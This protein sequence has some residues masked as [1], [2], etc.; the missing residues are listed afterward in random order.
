MP[1]SKSQSGLGTLIAI[2]AVTGT[3]GET[4]NNIAELA[5]VP[6]EFPEWKTA[7]VTSFASTIE[8]MKKIIKGST[9][10]TF[11][12]RRVST[13]AGQ[14]Q[15]QVAYQ[16]QANPYDFKITL[17]IN[18]AEG[19]TTQGDVITFSAYVLAVKS[20]VKP[21][22]IIDYEFDVQLDTDVTYVA[23]S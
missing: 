14:K 21:T 11:K 13:D 6:F 12:G 23:G 22:D 15:V 8:Q 18:A 3:A 9:K 16:D 5:E 17:P 20:T 10:Y 19:Q 4:F 2:G 7:D 1:A